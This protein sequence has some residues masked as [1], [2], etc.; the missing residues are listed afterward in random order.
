[1]KTVREDCAE[2]LVGMRNLKSSV[3]D[4]LKVVSNT[5]VTKGYTMKD[6]FRL[7]AILGKDDLEA[8]KLF[9][10]ERPIFKNFINVV[11]KFL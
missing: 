8:F 7:N 6:I 4:R 3:S 9:L 11:K 5:K 2:L 1:M 10:E